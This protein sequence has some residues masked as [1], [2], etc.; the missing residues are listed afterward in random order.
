MAGYE[1]NSPMLWQY[2]LDPFVALYVEEVSQHSSGAILVTLAIVRRHRLLEKARPVSDGLPRP[3]AA[4]RGHR[5]PSAPCGW[6][7]SVGTGL[8]PQT[9]PSFFMYIM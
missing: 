3:S 4:F 6:V 9:P 1:V 5:R 8:P 2:L 7:L